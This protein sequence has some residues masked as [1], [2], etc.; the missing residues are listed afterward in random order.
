MGVFSCMKGLVWQLFC[1]L[2]MLVAVGV[3]WRSLD[4][5]VAED[6]LYL[7]LEYILFVTGFL[8]AVEVFLY[9]QLPV[10]LIPD[11]I[12]IIGKCDDAMAVG[13]GVIGAVVAVYGYSQLQL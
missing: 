1:M 6:V 7:S 4:I 10:D 11:C 2:L 3:W 5:Y 13:V 8:V 12:P 9:T